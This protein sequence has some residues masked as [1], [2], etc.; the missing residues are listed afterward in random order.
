MPMMSWKIDAG[1]VL[2]VIVTIFG[3]AVS[4]GAMSAKLDD[5]AR[6]ITVVAV[7]VD[8]L[9]EQVGKIRDEQVRNSTKIEDL[10]RMG[11][12]AQDVRGA[13]GQDRKMRKQ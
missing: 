1:H 3:L 4:W 13:N 6:G 7:K 10:E 11:W 2:L 9:T 8:G 12:D 5:N